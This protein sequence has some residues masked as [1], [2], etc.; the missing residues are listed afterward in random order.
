VRVCLCHH[1]W[2]VSD[3][4]SAIDIMRHISHTKSTPP[5][6]HVHEILIHTHTH[7]HMYTPTHSHTHTHTHKHTHRQASHGKVR[8][9]VAPTQPHAFQLFEILGHVYYALL[10][11]GGAPQICMLQL[12]C[13]KRCVCACVCV[14][15][16]MYVCVCAR[17]CVCTKPIHMKRDL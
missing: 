14:C 4:T 1:C 6:I 12:W 10:C 15:V 9:S 17:V 5:F 11:D 7:T 13:S 16:S 3:T 2:C 8:N